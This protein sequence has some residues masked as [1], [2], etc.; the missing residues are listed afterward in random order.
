FND[1]TIDGWSQGVFD[2]TAGYTG[3]PLIHIT[4][5]GGLA[6]GLEMG[7][8]LK[9][10]LVVKGIA[11]TN[12]TIGV[13]VFDPDGSFSIVGSYIG[14]APGLSQTDAT[15]AGGNETGI[16]IDGPKQVT[17]GGTGTGE[18]NV[19]ASNTDVGVKIINI[20]ESGLKVLGNFIGTD[21]TGAANRGNTN[22]GIH[23]FQSWGV[24][25]GD[26]TTAGRNI[27]VG[28]TTGVGIEVE[29]SLE[30]DIRGNYIGVG[31]DGAT[32]LPNKI[33][34]HVNLAEDTDVG[35][36]TEG[37]RNV[38]SG[39]SEDQ[40]LLTGVC[41]CIARTRVRGNYIGTNAAGTAAVPNT[42][43][44]IHILDGYGI[45]IGG[46]DPGEGNLISGNGMDGV[47]IVGDYSE[48]IVVAGN[49][50]GTNAAGTAAIPN[51]RDGVS[52][53]PT[54]SGGPGPYRS[55][56]GSE[57]PGSGNLISGNGRHGVFA[58]RTRQDT[59]IFH[60]L[61]GVDASGAG[62]LPNGG[63]GILIRNAS[64]LIVRENIVANSGQAGIVMMPRSNAITGNV[65]TGNAIFNNQGIGID[66]TDDVDGAG[67][68][69][70]IT[71][72]NTPGA[73]DFPVLTTATTSNVGTVVG[74]TLTSIPGTS[75]R[76]EFF[77]S[78]SCDPSG[79]G[80]GRGYIGGFDVG[81]NGSGIAT[82]SAT[83]PKVADGQV[84]TATATNPDRQTSEF[85]LCKPIT[86]ASITVSPT[87][88]LTTSEAGTSATFQVALTT[89]PIADVTIALSSTRPSEGTVQQTSLTFTPQNALQAQTVTVTGVSDTV[90][91]GNQPYT[92]LTA[93]AVS[94]D[95]SYNGL[96]P[97]DVSVINTDATTLPTVTI[98]NAQ[99]TE[100]TGAT[101]S[102]AFAVTVSP[103]ST[104]TIT[105]NWSLQEGTAKIPFDV[106]SAFGTLTFTPGETSKPITVDIIGDSQVEGDETFTV[107]LNQVSNAVIG[108]QTGTGTILD[109]DIAG[110]ACSP[111]PVIKMTTTRSGIDDLVVTLVA[112][113]GNL[114]RITFGS[115][116]RPIQ[117]AIIQTINPSRTIEGTG[118]FIPP[119]GVK[120]QAF[121]I[122]RV[123]AGQPVMVDFEVED[124]CG[125]WKTFV[126][127]GNGG[128]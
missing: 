87:S 76:L 52:M 66:L 10:A 32:P 59:L 109:D 73:Q 72:P 20:S 56:I 5:G 121:V 79:Y 21:R 107:R 15:T 88:G 60:N 105:V 8:I 18:G 29:Y 98:G 110:S 19:I 94:T 54:G 89:T 77:A 9:G 84:L 83:L 108:N 45:I 55:I 17:I 58:R 57:V 80:E 69:D 86:T 14:V 95:P 92:V 13:H 70:G 65:I 35:G 120:Q 118:E 24:D 61:I 96:N 111:R 47:T 12:F 48:E 117:N 1:V 102:M 22:H 63:D 27:I 115:V 103:A 44:G 116:A 46:I 68:G 97:S 106:A 28:S 30:T 124:G 81:T 114:Q 64:R 126:G 43:N 4:N 128:F 119:A 51:A 50:I 53:L 7:G 37:R 122:H 93:A 112:G 101:V 33:G 38:I 82:F 49:R 23:I 42:A 104:Q 67:N 74:G 3:P 90:A 85:S 6:T 113:E 40:V 36:K 16:L 123:Q 125:S 11:I 100:G 127:S 26:G 71:P 41:G 99:V 78:P 31:Q 2:G 25:V 39:N 75:F 91:D 34:L 62:S